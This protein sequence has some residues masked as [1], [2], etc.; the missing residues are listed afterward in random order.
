MLLP[1]TAVPARVQLTLAAVLGL[2]ALALGGLLLAGGGGASERAT[3]TVGPSG[4]AGAVSPPGARAADFRLRDQD[5]APVSLGATR[6]QIT[7]LTFLY[8]SCEDTCPVAASQIGGAL[9]K[10]G[11]AAR[12]V[13]AIAVSVDP[14]NDTA[15]LARKFLLGRRLNGRM[16]FALGSRKQLRP[17][18]RSYGVRPQGSDPDATD[19][20]HSARVVVVD[21]RGRQRVAFPLDQLTPDA[22]A[23]DVGKLQAE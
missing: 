16:R 18:W 1:S 23:H 3:F 17:V 10:L 2:I 8:T 4:F 19:F 12:E 5:G 15:A 14:A 6:G 9:D 21:R 20:E 22:L 11:D 13:P 7:V